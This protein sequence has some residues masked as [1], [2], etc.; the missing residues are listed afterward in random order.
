MLWVDARCSRR[1]VLAWLAV[2]HGYEVS[3]IPTEC[4][5]LK[6]ADVSTAIMQSSSE[7]TQHAQKTAVYALVETAELQSKLRLFLIKHLVGIK[8]TL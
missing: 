1:D 2:V 3:F 8:D 4:F 7:H 5:Y 6:K